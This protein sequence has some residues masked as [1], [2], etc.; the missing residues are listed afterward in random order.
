MAQL[1]EMFFKWL[2]A[3]KFEV[4][5]AAF[6]LMIL[7]PIPM[8]DAAQAGDNTTIVV[9]LAIVILGNVLVLLVK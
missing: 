5:V 2:R 7:P 3:H 4:H 9:L 6:L 1:G 8:Y